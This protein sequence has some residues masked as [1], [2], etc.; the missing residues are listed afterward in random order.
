MGNK[1]YAG[2]LRSMNKSPRV[3]II[4]GNIDVNMIDKMLIGGHL[5]IYLD[6]YSVGSAVH[7]PHFVVIESAKGV[8]YNITDPWDGKTKKITKLKLLKGIN[9]L[10]RRFYFAPKLIQVVNE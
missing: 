2:V 1:K 4:G 5:I 9:E 8:H 3:S 7:A 6:A 10:K